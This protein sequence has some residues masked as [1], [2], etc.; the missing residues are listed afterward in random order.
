MNTSRM[1]RRLL[2]ALAIVLVSLS[3]LATAQVPSRITA[4]VNAKGTIR[5]IATGKVCTAKERLITWPTGSTAGGS[6]YQRSATAK[7]LNVPTTVVALCDAPGD[8]ATG[9]GYHWEPDPVVSTN[10]SCWVQT[11]TSCRAAGVCGGPAGKD[12]WAVTAWSCEA[13]SQAPVMHVYV[14]CSQPTE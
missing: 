5:I 4:C 14:T 10:S 2:I 11:S 13:A 12:G 7:L 1:S 9:G 8:T 3:A 6:Y